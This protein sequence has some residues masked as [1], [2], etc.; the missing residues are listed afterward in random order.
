MATVKLPLTPDD[1]DFT[2]QVELEGRTYGFRFLWNDASEA[3]YMSL[4]D[5]ADNPIAAGVKLTVDY[6]M[7][8]RLA[9]DS[10]P[11]GVLFAKDSLGQE[12]DPGRD[13]LGVRVQLYYEE[14][15]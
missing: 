9:L 8:G 12:Q 7:L 5:E 10:L 15:E 1:P 11:P 13:D 4:Y 14:S 6:D 3:W 2:F